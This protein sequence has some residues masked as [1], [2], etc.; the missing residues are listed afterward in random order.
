MQK[1]SDKNPRTE[2]T[3]DSGY[4]YSFFIIQLTGNK[5]C[6]NICELTNYVDSAQLWTTVSLTQRCPVTALN[7]LLFV[8]PHFFKLK[9]KIVNANNTV[10][11]I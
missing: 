3:V 9:G 2:S 1:V 7:I 4:F 10:I 8:Y 6:A 5:T 11:S